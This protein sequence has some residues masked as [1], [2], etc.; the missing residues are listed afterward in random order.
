MLFKFKYSDYLSL[1]DFEAFDGK[2]GAYMKH[3]AVPALH[4]AK[5]YTRSFIDNDT[6]YL[7]VFLIKLVTLNQSNLSY[8]ALHTQSHKI[9][10]NSISTGTSSTW[11]DTGW[12]NAFRDPDDG[13]PLLPT[14]SKDIV[15][16]IS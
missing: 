15:V 9:F 7:A 11:E 5:I 1:E 14:D 2:A 13:K 4:G 10:K 12:D 6:Y 8:D 3:S 16:Y